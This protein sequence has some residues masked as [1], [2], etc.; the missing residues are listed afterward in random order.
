LRRNLELSCGVATALLGIIISWMALRTDY[1]T[2]LRLED[3]FHPVRDFLLGAVRNPGTI[4]TFWDR[5]RGIFSMEEVDER[6]ELGNGVAHF[7]QGWVT[8]LY[9]PVLRIGR[10]L[11]R[12]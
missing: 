2:A 12:H 11:R 1:Q 3:K 5:M 6:S 8:Q 7:P 4:F 10:V 9:E